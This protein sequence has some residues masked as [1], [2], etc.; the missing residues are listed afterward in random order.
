VFVKP[1][2]GLLVITNTAKEGITKLTK[3]ED[4]VVVW[5]GTSDIRKN[6]SPIILKW[7]G[8]LVEGIQEESEVRDERKD[9]REIKET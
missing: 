1:G 9:S 5:G 8:N 3:K 6:V 7:K 2:D 4:V